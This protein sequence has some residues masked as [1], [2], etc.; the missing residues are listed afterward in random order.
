MVVLI[1]IA[2]FFG[3][4]YWWLVGNWFARIV[5]FLALIPVCWVTQAHAIYIGDAATDF[6]LI[7]CCG[8]IAWLVSGLPRYLGAHVKAR[9]ADWG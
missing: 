6:F 3:V 5:V 1:G 7:A 8:V 4:L 2:T 9:Q